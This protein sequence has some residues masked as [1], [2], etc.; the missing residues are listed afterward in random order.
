MNKN[1]HQDMNIN[2]SQSERRKM[3]LVTQNQRVFKKV[4]H[5]CVSHLP[6]VFSEMVEPL[7]RRQSQVKKK[8]EHLLTRHYS[9]G[10][11]K[12]SLHIFLTGGGTLA[13]ID[14]GRGSHLQGTAPTEGGGG[15]AGSKSW[16]PPTHQ[17]PPLPL[18][19]HAWISG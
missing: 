6:V 3:N 13:G 8:K 14:T 1:T 16:D 18:L 5:P 11:Y 2:S 15:P 17:S 9:K 4:S 19:H 12:H 7:I 10:L